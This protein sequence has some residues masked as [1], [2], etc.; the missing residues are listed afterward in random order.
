MAMSFL[1]GYSQQWNTAHITAGNSQRQYKTYHHQSGQQQ[2]K[3]VLMLHGLGGSMNDVDLT[4]WKAIADTANMLL[5]SPQALDYTMPLAGNIGACWN[6]GIVLE[7]TPLGTVTLNPD[8][9]DVGFLK[10]LIDTV[11][12]RFSVNEDKIYV[13]G[14]SNGGF[15][16][17]RLTC[18]AP[19]QFRAIASASGTKALAIQNCLGKTLPM[20]HFHGTDDG[21][22]TWQGVFNSGIITAQAGISV[23]SLMQYWKN[24]HQSAYVDSVN[25]GSAAD[26]VWMTHYRYAHNGRERTAL[27]KI[28]N[29]THSW[30]NYA[31]TNNKFDMALEMWKFFLDQDDA[32]LSIA[33]HKEISFSIYPNPAGDQ[34]HISTGQKDWKQYRITDFMGRTLQQ[35]AFRDAGIDITTLAAGSYFLTLTNENGLNYSTRFIKKPS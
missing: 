3:V 2:M 8:V 1:A 17:Q 6:S 10:A 24:R 13:C 7:N 15:M 27:Y 16:A 19:G 31:N 18:E 22:V 5:V 29:G 4:S 21:V 25:F 35:A 20:A 33:A 26:P 32:S 28:H 34:L 12:S 11:K 23:D 14:F 9:D 30:Y